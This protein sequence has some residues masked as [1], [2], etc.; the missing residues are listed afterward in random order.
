M[1]TTQAQ[2]DQPFAGASRSS[3][4]VPPVRP[5]SIQPDAPAH[6]CPVCGQPADGEFCSERCERDSVEYHYRRLL[7]ADAAT[8]RNFR[9]C[10]LFHAAE[11]QSSV[12]LSPGRRRIVEHA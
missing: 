11:N 7:A 4:G 6:F 2:S 8:E 9:R 10:C 5:P 3:Q 1:D 12:S